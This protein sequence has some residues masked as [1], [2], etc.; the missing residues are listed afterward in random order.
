MKLFSA[1]KREE[2]NLLEIGGGIYSINIPS[3]Y[4]WEYDEEGT[5][6]FYSPGEETITLRIT[7]LSLERKDGK[8]SHGADIVIEDAISQNLE[9]EILAD[10][11]TFLETPPEY[12][13]ENGTELIMQFCYI[14]RDN[15]LIIISSTTI[16]NRAESDAVKVMKDDL[17]QIFR[18]VIRL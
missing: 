2:S 9:Y 10:G 11:V 13:T 16:L 5:L 18:S 14:G 7:V 1:F 12:Q 3:S 8:T 15:S 6:L 17:K 4:L